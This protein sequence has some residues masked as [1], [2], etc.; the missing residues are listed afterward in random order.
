MKSFKLPLIM[1]AVAA[2]VLFAVLG[3]TITDSAEEQSTQMPPAKLPILKIDGKEDPN[4]YLQSLDIQVEVTGNIASTRYTMVFKNKTDRV[5]EGELTFPLPDG[6]TVTHYAL[7]IN[8][9]MREAV[10]VE[11]ARAT[12][13]F[14]E[15][16]QREVD[17]G[18][19]ERVE[20]NNFRTRIYPFPRQGTRTISIGYE[21][22][23]SLEKGLLYY[24][25]PMAYP[26]SLENFATKATAWQDGKQI[27]VA[28]SSQP[29]KALVF[30]LPAPANIP[31]VMMQ[32]AQGSY[33]FLA[34][35]VPQVEARKKQWSDE[36]AIIWDV[37]LSG[38]QRDIQREIEILDIIF[39][40]KKNAN[41]HLYFLNNKLKKVTKGK[42]LELKKVLET[43]V[44]DGGTDFSQINLNDI[45]GDEILFF[46]DGISTLSDADFFK[47]TNAESR[48]IHCIVS[49]SKVDYSTMRLI[50]GK[51]KGK[52]INLN[53]LSSGNLKNELLNETLMFLG[54][55]HGN[56]LREVYPS[57]AT[58]VYGNFSIAGISDKDVAELTLLFGFGDKVEKKINVKLNAKDAASQGNTYRIWAQKKIAELDLEYEKNRAEL[59]ELGQQFGIVTRNTSLIVLELISDY[60]RYGIEPPDTEPELQAEYRRRKGGERKLLPRGIQ[61]ATDRNLD[62]ALQN[63]QGLQTSGKSELGERRGSATGGFN[64]GYAEGGSGG[65]GDMLGGL[66]GGSGGAIGTKARGTLRAPSARDID[67]GSG[68]ASRS[69][70]EVM[71]VVNA[72]MPGLRNIY[73]RYL[74]INPGFTGRVTLKF[75]IAPSGD[76]TNITIVSSTTS[77]PEFD[78]AVKNMVGTWKWKIIKSGNT[79]PTIP[80]NFSEPDFKSSTQSPPPPP[81]PPI[82]PEPVKRPEPKPNLLNQAVHAAGN[83]KRW[84]NIDFAPQKPNVPQK[85]RYPIPDE[86]KRTLNANSSKDDSAKASGYLSKLTGKTAEDYQIYLELRNDYAS[87]PTFYFDMADWFYKL[88]DKETALRILTSIAD[89]ELENASLYRLLG[90]KFKE[91]GEYMLQKFVTQK[92]IEWRPME[93]QSYRDYA[94][95]LADNGETQAALDSLYSLLTK[96]FSQNIIR[97]SQGIEE[98][99]VTEI[100]H[101]IAKNPK[102]NVSQIDKRLLIN[103][104]VDIRVVINWNMNNVD[105]DLHVKDPSG[106][107]CYYSRRQ[108]SAGGRI[109]ADNTGGYGPE[110]F[111]LKRATKG[112]YQ[113]YVNYFRAREFAAD[114]P[115]TIM[116]EIFTKYA[117]KTEERQVVTLQLSNAKSREDRKVQVA[118]FDF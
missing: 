3:L 63:V 56:A 43:A 108:T 1:L 44:F 103:I 75:T 113:V 27:V 80:F 105:I 70:Q 26:D 28:E 24:R 41:I 19:L 53:A 99:V 48:P 14:E 116:A 37:S 87:L 9:K 34:S 42:W 106:E 30:A 16:Q 49:S 21:E 83:I 39:A 100:N 8:G 11:K 15:I 79:T 95:A 112:K 58:P 82:R 91:Y 6:R 57:I 109:S 77:Y 52:F 118:E 60:I 22:E 5:L 114:G 46:S 92:V 101:L 12:Q 47:N 35:V 86:T 68:D 107:E 93:P 74:K 71:A 76:I 54:A 4:V 20:G 13:V 94:L 98:V 17:P 38:S 66:A 18:I 115:A 7:D 23:L 102:L 78:N 73:N 25:L 59:T 31:Q 89:L 2:V 55:E 36:L 69:R 65:I 64:E 62:R 104:P 110:Q 84:W 32:A 67:M 97:R 96:S 10:P 40:E 50:A 29:S 81:P 85:T 90:Y 61:G 111:M 51:T 117:D 88:G 45:A 72:R 33:Y